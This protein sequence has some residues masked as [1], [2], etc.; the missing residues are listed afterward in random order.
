MLF[1]VSD[2]LVKKSMLL[3][4][5]NVSSSNRGIAISY[6]IDIENK[7]CKCVNCTKHQNKQTNKQEESQQLTNVNYHQSGPTRMTGLTP[8]GVIL[9]VIHGSS[10][11]PFPGSLVSQDASRCIFQQC[12]TSSQYNAE[13]QSCFWTHAVGIFTPT[14]PEFCSKPF[15]PELHKV[16]SS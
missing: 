1:L 4:F 7:W 5:K 9:S 15:S 11:S 16:C 8:I 3:F 12:S 13:L 6:I 14:A 10:P 2:Q